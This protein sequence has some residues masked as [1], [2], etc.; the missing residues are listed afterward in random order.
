MPRDVYTAPMGQDREFP[1]KPTFEEQKVRLQKIYRIISQ[2]NPVNTAEEVY[3]IVC[4]AVES[5]ENEAESK[6]L[7]ST[8]KM[9]TLPLNEK[10]VVKVNDRTILYQIYTHHVLLMGDNGSLA[11]YRYNRDN[12]PKKD[13]LHLTDILKNPKLI[14]AL[15]DK[16]KY[17]DLSEQ[18]FILECEK[19]GRDDNR[20]FEELLGSI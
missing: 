7:H 6:G 1:L 5:V 14:L 13:N 2:R 3:K 12:M 8:K 16:E 15:R 20:S 17:P 18:P 9:S 19:R 10:N 4:D 11:I